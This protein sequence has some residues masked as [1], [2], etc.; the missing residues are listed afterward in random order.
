[1]TPAAAAKLVV[2]QHYDLPRGAL[3]SRDRTRAVAHPRQ[4]AMAICHDISTMSTTEIG[5]AFGHRDHTT[6]MYGIRIAKQRA[7]EDPDRA[8]VY[9]ALRTSAVLM[10][11]NPA[12][13]GRVPVFKSVRGKLCAG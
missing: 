5:L 1:M 12:F 13:A 6:V 10:L 9:Q 11:D 8:A 4:L 3:T 2:S 7:K